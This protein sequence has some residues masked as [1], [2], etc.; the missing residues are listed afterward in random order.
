MERSET[1]RQKAEAL[2]RDQGGTLKMSDAVRLGITRY[3]LYVMLSEGALERLAGGVYRLAD[4]PSLGNPDLVTV[5]QRI[6]RGVICLISALAFHELTT[7]IPHVIWVAMKRRSRI[8]KVE[9]RLRVRE[10]RSQN[11]HGGTVVRE[12]VKHR[13]ADLQE[14]LLARLPL[15]GEPDLFG[16]RRDL[17][18]D[19]L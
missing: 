1:S 3:T 2:F 9:W 6:P 5:A 12:P 10:P 19:D 18:V 11:C 14:Y 13:D 4:L 7:Q 8:P 16:T 17:V 15:K